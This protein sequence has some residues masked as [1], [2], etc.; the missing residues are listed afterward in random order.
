MTIS[1]EEHSDFVSILHHSSQIGA[2]SN[3]RELMKASRSFIVRYFQLLPTVDCDIARLYYLDEMSQE[4][5]SRMF[6]IT[7]AAVSRRLKFI[8]E[9]LK[10]LMKMP[11]LN[12]IVVREELKELFPEPLFE[13]A[14]FFYWEGAQNRVKYY[15]ETSQSGAAN[16]FAKVLEHIRGIEEPEEGCEDPQAHRLHYLTL[17]YREYFEFIAGKSNT[18]TYLY[19]KQDNLRVNAHY[20]GPAI[21][22]SAHVG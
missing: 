21:C 7:Q 5:I 18:I 17:I 13:F 19:K 16:K 11:H 2:H 8:K 9:R 10:F 4:Q 20:Q 22:I 14:Y 3:F 12:P 6:D 15:I 1:Y